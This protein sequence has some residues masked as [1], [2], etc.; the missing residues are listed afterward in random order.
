MDFLKLLKEEKLKAKSK[1]QTISS[2]TLSTS[3][4]AARPSPFP[5]SLPPPQFE[6]LQEL[7]KGGSFELEEHRVCPEMKDLYYISDILSIED[8]QRLLANT[9]A[10][11]WTQLSTR[12]LQCYGDEHPPPLTAVE[13]RVG[14][15]G[16][17]LKNEKEKEKKEKKEKSVLLPDWGI[18][19]LGQYLKQLG[20]LDFREGVSIPVNHVLINKYSPEE[21]IMHHTDG[22]AYSDTV[23]IVSLNETAL[24]SFKRNL[25]SEEIGIVKDEA[26]VSLVLRPRSLLVF[27][28]WLYSHALH[29]IATGS[30][31]IIE[32]TCCNAAQTGVEVGHALVKTKPRTSITIRRKL[33]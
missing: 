5:I 4:C 22:P 12:K 3:T 20:V 15:G 25:S 24:F 6:R 10:C 33:Y 32:D 21:G 2:T 1:D 31:Q 13:V 26:L 7:V 18:E 28:S 29:G 16:D 8:E 27:S 14:V 19:Q 17:E 23:A 11:A 9:E 30:V